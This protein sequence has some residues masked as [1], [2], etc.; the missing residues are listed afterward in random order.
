MWDLTVAS[1]H[2]F[3]VASVSANVLVHN[4]GV[5]NNLAPPARTTHIVKGDETDGGHAWPGAAGKSPF[6][7]SWS[8]SKIMNTISDIATD[9]KAWNNAQPQGSRSLLSGSVDGIDVDVVVRNSDNSI[10][11][12][13]QLT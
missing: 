3:Y 1:D 10:V 11:T 2:D 12:V 7:K 4:C 9:P 5:D 13:F 6:P 8:D